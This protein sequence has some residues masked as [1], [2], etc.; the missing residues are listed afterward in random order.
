[1][2][3][4]KFAPASK[5]YTP[6]TQTNT[7]QVSSEIF[8]GGLSSSMNA[9]ELKKEMSVFGAVSTSR[10]LYYRDGRPRGFGFVTFEEDEVTQAIVDK[11]FI[12]LSNC[13]VECKLAVSKVESKQLSEKAV[14]RKVIAEG[15]ETQSEEE[16]S[17]YFSRFGAVSKVRFAHKKNELKE[18]SIDTSKA[19]V[20]FKTEESAKSCLEHGSIHQIL[21]SFVSVV[22]ASLN[23]AQSGAQGLSEAGTHYSASS[24]SREIKKAPQPSEL[25]QQAAAQNT[26]STSKISNAMREVLG[27]AYKHYSC[28]LHNIQF[29]LP[30]QIPAVIAAPAPAKSFRQIHREVQAVFMFGSR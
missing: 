13:V 3:A 9:E 1:M 18:V 21:D 25:P 12:K 20:T 23:S 10:I 30:R 19:I 26:T 11:K 2:K 24:S 15:L 28:A 4:I 14:L 16:L 17:N 27:S 5:I 7:S 29:R 6:S 22:A 8:V